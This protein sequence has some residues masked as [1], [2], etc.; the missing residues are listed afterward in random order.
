MMKQVGIKDILSTLF[1]HFCGEFIFFIIFISL[2]Q[3]SSLGL[4][5]GLMGS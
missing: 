3:Y 2:T 5:Y 1:Y 4:I